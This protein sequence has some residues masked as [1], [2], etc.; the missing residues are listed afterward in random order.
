M[1]IMAHTNITDL[2][3][4][5]EDGDRPTG[6]DFEN[7][8]DSCHNTK[9]D[10]DVLITGTLTVSGATLIDD[11]LTVEDTTTLKKSL[12]VSSN[13]TVGGSSILTG[14]LTVSKGTSLSDTLFVGKDTILNQNLNVKSALSVD[15]MTVLGDSTTV[16]G[17]LTLK[18]SLVAE[19]DISVARDVSITGNLVNASQSDLN[20]VAIGG[21]LDVQGT[22]TSHGDIHVKGEATLDSDVHIKGDLTVDGNVVLKSDVAGTINVGDSHHD[23]VVFSADVASNVTPDETER[24][25]LGSDVKRWDK[26]Y[27]TDLDVT[28]TVDGRDVSEDGSTLDGIVNDMSLVSN[29]SAGWDETQAIVNEREDA[30][31]DT[32]TTVGAFSASWEESL[33]I[34]AVAEDVAVVAAISADWTDTRTTVNT[35]SAT[36]NIDKLVDL[37]DV[38]AV[39]LSNNSVLRYDSGLDKWV[40]STTED[41]KATGSITILLS[42]TQYWDGRTVTLTDNNDP[43]HTVT[44]TGDVNI[45]HGEYNKVTDWEYKVGVNGAVDKNQIAESFAVAINAAQSTG[46]LEIA[47]EVID[48]KINLSQ[49][50]GGIGGNVTIDGTAKNITSPEV[51]G[52]ASKFS[53]VLTYNNGNL[54]T[55]I[56]APAAGT[57]YDRTFVTDSNVVENATLIG[58]DWQ[59]YNI[60]VRLNGG[61]TQN[62]M[63]QLPSGQTVE[64]TGGVD[65]I[66][67]VGPV[68][69]FIDFT[70]GENPDAF[71]ALDDTPASYGG[72]AGKLVKVKASEDGL[73]FVEDIALSEV[74][75]T[76]AS[77]NEATT[78]VNETSANWNDTRSSLIAASGAWNEATTVTN[79]TSAA[80][81][82][83]T[84]VTND[85]S[86]DWNDTRSSMT[87]TS[88]DWND[89]RSSLMA[90]SGDWNESQSVVNETS[91]A[92]NE[93]TTVTNDTSAAW[94]DTRSSLMA[95]S[96]AWNEATTVT[97][98]T[99]AAWNEATTV[100]NDTSA[101][102]NE[103][104]TVTNDTSAAWNDT[105]SSLMAAS[106]DWTE[107]QLVVNTTSADWNEVKTEV[108][109][110]SAEW[111]SVYSHINSVSGDGF[112]TLDINGK[113]LTTQIP[114]LSITRVHT[115]NNPGDVALLNPGTG[116]QEG[117]VV[118]VTS[119][120]DNLIAQVDNPTGDYDSGTKDYSG[121]AK[122]ALPDGLV[123]TVNG[124]PGPSVV[125]NPDDMMDDVT[126]HKFVSQ[127][128][129]N[130][131]NDT[132]T[133]L[134]ATS[135]DWNDTRTTL[136][137][138]S[139]D[140]NDTR[141]TLGATSGDWNDTRSSLM[142]TSGDWNDTRVSLLA[143]SGD[144]ND[145]R[146]SL[147]STSGDWNSVYSFVNSD[148]A[149]NNTQYNEDTYVN[150]TGDKMTGNLHLDGA[151]LIV[152]G[153]ITMAGDLIHENDTGTRIS[154]NDDIINLETNGQEF[155]TIDGT[156][157]TP[158]AV[159]INDPATTA[160]H[161]QVKTPDDDCAFVI[162]GET[163]FVNIGQCIGDNTGGLLEVDGTAKFV[164]A[165]VKEQL[166]VIGEM[167]SGVDATP[168]HDIFSTSTD[169]KG[170]LTVW[171]SISSRD[172]LVVNNTTS[173][174][175]DII[176]KGDIDGL[177]NTKISGPVETPDG[178]TS[179]AYKTT[180]PDGSIKEGV[181]QDV[182]IGGHVL[183]I[184]NGIIVE[185]TDE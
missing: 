117:D 181:T 69:T 92:W 137:A 10:T 44:F 22:S 86:G 23:S 65:T 72:H 113:L 102:W 40:A 37:A 136:G 139:G 122:L 8:L 29:A 89:T 33:D 105:R 109:S 5:F 152:G 129:K 9:Q 143:T 166:S 128:E 114:E 55:D 179:S 90:A 4:K 134:G 26:I 35:N 93:A 103:A 57:Q 171:G 184:V 135:G 41:E 126:A 67:E 13:L 173:V 85:T 95:A 7:L 45:T 164:N 61:G 24:Y 56:T 98:D 34:E 71:E 81:N 53:G 156:A 154:F 163:G 110:T 48:D 141:T 6:V 133:T 82:E 149:T 50:V 87:T 43:I 112:A 104:T 146:S 28:D 20:N 91:G 51:P 63:G 138:T 11:T 127:D 2:K 142:S 49:L 183:H 83:A 172:E 144:W 160:I 150:V 54:Q 125:L 52:V 180:A 17:L 62:V 168:L 175:G 39:G 145:T 97:N 124:K 176:L 38:D 161:F 19:K 15:G 165:V 1:T 25:N 77:W 130:D 158:D 147:M 16:M 64:I 73:E 84:T 177:D 100:T 157:P 78:V 18:E 131:W 107:T 169:I 58:P 120:H 111:N 148:S 106:G 119:T 66:P 96:G 42:D 153:N 162:D 68:A 32:R 75:V 36:W 132:R 30:W 115:A 121:Y 46:N 59:Q 159:I 94:N 21:T 167:V 3:G 31:N 88:G 178:M 27:V 123:Q 151:E 80:W 14:T 99:S 60:V 12:S 70:G 47:A 116:I 76:S 79:D 140:W 185:V 74:S 155:I 108:N 170:D 118:V 182:N 174:S 101:A